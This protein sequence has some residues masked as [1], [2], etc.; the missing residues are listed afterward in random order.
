MELDQFLLRAEALIAR[1]E[2][3]LPPPAPAP[4]WSASAFRWRKRQNRGH[5]EAVRHPHRIRLDDLCEVMLDASLCALGGLTPYPVLSALRHFPED[6]D[7]PPAATVHPA[8]AT[9]GTP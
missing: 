4:N 3:L 1:I 7:R 6:F 5:L 2:T 8:L 9:G